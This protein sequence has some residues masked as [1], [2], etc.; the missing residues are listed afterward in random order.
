MVDSR[1]KK[2]LGLALG[3]AL[4]L[5]A[6]GGGAWWLDARS[7][8]AGE[9]GTPENSWPTTSHLSRAPDAYTLVVALH[10]ECPC[11][12]ATVEELAGILARTEGRLT[13]RLLMVQYEEI[14]ERAEDSPLWK[15]AA[16]IPGVT[17]VADLR[18]EEIQRFAARTSGET[19]LYDPRGRLVFRGGVTAARGHV[20]DNPG[21][22]AVCDLVLH[23]STSPL[24]STPVFGCAL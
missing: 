14:P 24:V 8:S 6:A 18:G 12:S 5:A 7:F 19:R 21:Q 13:A 23:A 15:K 1:T 3:L 2:S 11:S 10:P 22:A 4:W 16:R 20:G 9:S 17:L